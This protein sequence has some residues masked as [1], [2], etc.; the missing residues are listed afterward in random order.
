MK[1]TAKNW[2]QWRQF[3]SSPCS[4]WIFEFYCHIITYYSD[5]HESS[6]AIHVDCRHTQ[7]FTFRNNL[8]YIG[9]LSALNTC[10]MHDMIYKH[11]RSYVIKQHTY[12]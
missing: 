11:I 5:G 6:R 9:I 10:I 4:G 8:S 3:V 1:A 12:Q 7:T 2:V